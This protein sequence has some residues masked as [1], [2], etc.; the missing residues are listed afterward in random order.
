[1]LVLGKFENICRDR[2]HNDLHLGISSMCHQ[3][4]QDVT[5]KGVLEKLFNLGDCREQRLHKL[6]EFWLLGAMLDE[7]S[8]PEG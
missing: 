1:M 3:G 6:A 8:A 4:P 7:A 5:A 2:R